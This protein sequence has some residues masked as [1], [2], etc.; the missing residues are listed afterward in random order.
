MNVY[1]YFYFIRLNSVVL[2][3]S[4]QS[5]FLSASFD[6]SVR[7]KSRNNRCKVLIVKIKISF[8]FIE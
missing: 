1:D 8:A 6:I 2:V 4:I 5:R 3:V 7:N